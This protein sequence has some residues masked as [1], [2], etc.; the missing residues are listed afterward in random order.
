MLAIHG[1]KPVFLALDHSFSVPE[2]LRG[3]SDPTA[4]VPESR[5]SH[6][7]GTSLYPQAACLP[8][9]GQSAPSGV[10]SWALENGPHV[11]L[12]PRMLIQYTLSLGIVPQFCPLSTSAFMSQ[13][14]LLD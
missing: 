6:P 3:P 1:I 7:N 13:W 2:D 14:G 5:L 12:L 10:P 11:H 9:G 4:L 8:M